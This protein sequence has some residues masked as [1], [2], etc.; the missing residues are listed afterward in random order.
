MMPVSLP[1]ELEGFVAQELA[2]ERYR[3]REDLFVDAVRVLRD[4]RAVESPDGDWFALALEQF[5]VIVGL[6]PGWDSNGA[7]SPDPKLVQVAA[8]VL[9]WLAKS[10]RVSRP[11][12]NPTRRGGIQFEWEAG[13]RSFELE[14]VSE[15]RVTYFFQDDETRTEEEGEL[16]PHA[17]LDLI[18]DYIQRVDSSGRT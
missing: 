4:R 13:S 3:S 11:H 12:I 2:H 8:G 16:S 7:V 14:V 17:P 15:D 6:P 5:R 9:Y 10:G 1:S 18:A